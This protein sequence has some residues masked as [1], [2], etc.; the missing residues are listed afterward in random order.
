MA[1][2]L[3]RELFESCM[4]KKFYA[5]F[6]EEIQYEIELIDVKVSKRIESMDLEPYSLLFRADKS[7]K[8]SNQGLVSLKSE[9]TGEISLFLIPRLPDIDGIYYEVIIS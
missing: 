6:S 8:I 5:S 3:T 7:Q 1:I 9:K 2:A 4:N